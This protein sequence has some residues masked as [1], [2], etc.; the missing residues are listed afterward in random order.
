MTANEGYQRSQVWVKETYSVREVVMMR[1][2]I[3]VLFIP[4][5]LQMLAL[6]LN[7]ITLHVHEILYS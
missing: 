4:V 7:S 5:L 3:L 6:I 1:F 2:I